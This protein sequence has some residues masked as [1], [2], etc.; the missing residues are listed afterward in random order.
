MG[1]AFDAASRR[2]ERLR[3]AIAV[4]RGFWSGK[5]FTLRGEHYSIHDLVGFPEPVQRPLPILIGGGGRKL[6]SLAAQAAEIVGINPAA[7]SGAHDAATDLD[8]TAGTTDEK[9]SWV[10]E[11]AGARFDALE[12]SMQIY[13]ECV[14]DSRA[15]GD[16]VLT[17]RYAF[18]LEEARQVPYAWVGSIDSICEGLEA[19]RERWGVSYWIVP[20]YAMET[21]AEVV[22]RMT[23]R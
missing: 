2:I 17:Q 18:S 7:R 22:E 13:A 23:G 5:T 6:L 1:L 12:L 21:M 16:R 4:L 8:S 15:E 9:L 19:K 11:A 14:T 10:Q 20:D 3:E